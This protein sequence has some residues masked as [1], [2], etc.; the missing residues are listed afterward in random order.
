MQANASTATNFDAPAASD[1]WLFGWDPLRALSP[2]G[3]T[4]MAVP[5]SGNG[6]AMRALYRRSLRPWLF[7]ASLD[8]L[9]HLGPDLV[10]DGERRAQD[11]PFTYRELDGPPDSLRYLL[12]A[13]DGRAFPRDP[14]RRGAAA[15]LGATSL[16]DLPHYY[17]R[18]APSS[19]T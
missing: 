13:R 4:A 19:S 3:Q 11:A 14:L 12:S 1:D 5:V 17:Y 6:S 8:D 9:R 18:S 15:G 16:R 2:C 7:A 10:E